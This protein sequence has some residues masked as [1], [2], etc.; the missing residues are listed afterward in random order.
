MLSGGDELVC[1]Q[2]AQ[3]L[4]ADGNRE[5]E[6]LKRLPDNYPKIV[7]TANPMDVGMADWLLED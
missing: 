1:Y 2:V 5:I 3:H 6:N 4:P 7:L